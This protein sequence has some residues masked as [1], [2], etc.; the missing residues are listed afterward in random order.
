MMT[1][2]HQLPPSYNV[3]IYKAENSFESPPT[4]STLNDNSIGFSN[5]YPGPP[6]TDGTVQI[7]DRNQCSSS[8]TNQTNLH[9]II[10]QRLNHFLIINTF[11]WILLGIV[12][13]GLQILLV[14]T[15]SVVYYYF[16]FWSGTLLIT[17]GIANLLA[18][19]SGR[20]LNF[21]NLL[22][23]FI[24]QMIL[25]GSIF[26]IGVAILLT[27]GCDD[28][29]LGNDSPT[30]PCSHSYM[31]VNIILCVIVGFGTLQSIVDVCVALV[32]YRRFPNFYIN[33]Q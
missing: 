16:G 30:S 13:I 25:V 10:R 33:Q 7:I 12:V 28:N 5:N 20:N 14:A 24:L 31:V 17:V 6:I 32:A 9:A 26:G 15:Q 2:G 21:K 22:Y 19:R 1:N 27:D 23:W 8:S 11:I 3:A 4:Y 18:K 29:S